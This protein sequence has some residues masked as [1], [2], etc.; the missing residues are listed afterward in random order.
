MKTYFARFRTLVR[1]LLGTRGSVI[2]LSSG[3]FFKCNA[4][5]VI[6][7]IEPAVNFL[8]DI[9]NVNTLKL[10]KGNIIWPHI[11]Y[12]T[13]DVPGL[14]KA[15]KFA[16]NQSRDSCGSFVDELKPYLDAQGIPILDFRQLTTGVH[17]Y[18]GTH[19]GYG[20]NMMKVQML[21]NY[22]D[23]VQK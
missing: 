12:V 10:Q 14:L 2:V 13:P 6:S 3:I 5:D 16:Q 15:S 21:L 19:Y 7:R 1:T 17:S 18:D 11:I 4:T 8:K 20:V 23:A 9:Y 22:L